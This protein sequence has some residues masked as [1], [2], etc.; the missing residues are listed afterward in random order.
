MKRVALVNGL[1]ASGK[2]Q[3]SRALVER[4]GWPLLTLDSI[5]EPF[6]DALGS[7]DR[8]W[9]RTLG[10]AAFAAIWTIVADA[11]GAS[12]F[13]IDAW[14]GFQPLEVLRGHLA[15]A[16]IGGVVEVWCHAPGEVLAARYLARL[17]ERHPGHP[18]AEY[19]PELAA[20]AAT[21]SALGISPVFDH[22]STRPIDVDGLVTWIGKMWGVNL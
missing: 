9:S 7:G 14:F 3:V 11:P 15:R 5:K 1:P 16:G 12:T 22:D 8:T 13:A 2:T 21:A 10:S 18:G 4:T 19:A 17:A 6:F 20:K